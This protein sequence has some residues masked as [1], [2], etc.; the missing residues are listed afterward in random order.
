MAFCDFI[1]WL[2]E[3]I[4]TK[5]RCAKG[6]KASATQETVH[7]PP[8]QVRFEEGAEAEKE[9][10]QGA[11][12]ITDDVWNQPESPKPDVAVVRPFKQG[13]GALSTPI[14]DDV[15]NQSESPKPDVA[16]IRSFKEGWGGVPLSTIITDD[17]WNQPESPKPDVAVVRPFKE[18]WGG[19]PL[20]TPITDD[21]WNQPESP[22]PDKG[23]KDGGGKAPDE[24]F[25][26][27]LNTVL[28]IVDSW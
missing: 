13:W 10:P 3:Q 7:P 11:T 9:K 1:D 12:I 4:D 23:S 28:L 18:G 26:V 19:V 17:V 20:S 25:V 5:W 21:V 27:C 2:G 15:W 22:K 8:N 6:G 14:T 24:G 16:V